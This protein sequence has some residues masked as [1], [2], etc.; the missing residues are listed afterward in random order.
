MKANNT[1]ALS[2]EILAEYRS[3]V[4]VVNDSNQGKN[5]VRSSPIE[6]INTRRLP[7]PGLK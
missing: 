5:R 4:S 3:N 6:V 2:V 7:N 1:T